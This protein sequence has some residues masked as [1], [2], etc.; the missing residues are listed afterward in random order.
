MEANDTAEKKKKKPLLKNLK[1]IKIRGGEASTEEKK[2]FTR[3]KGKRMV[4]AGS[5]NR[6]VNHLIRLARGDG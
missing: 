4:Y 5:F 1:C 6:S 3:R 2:S